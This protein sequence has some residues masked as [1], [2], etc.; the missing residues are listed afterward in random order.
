MNRLH[1]SNLSIVGVTARPT[2]LY[3]VPYS[4]VRCAL[5][6]CT[7]RPTQLYVALYSSN[8]EALLYCGSPLADT[9]LTYAGRERGR[10][11]GRE[12]QRERE[13]RGRTKPLQLICAEDMGKPLSYTYTM[14]ATQTRPQPHVVTCTLALCLVYTTFHNTALSTTALL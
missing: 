11:R 4:A 12:R 7:L 13:S 2:Q 10:D 3:V 14:S 6:S 9:A 1:S 5:H 8:R